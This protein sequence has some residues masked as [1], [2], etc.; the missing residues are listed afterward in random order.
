M[1]KS[2][3]PENAKRVFKGVIYDVYQW[4]Q[5][6]FD[7]SKA[8]FE[9]LDRPNTIEV[10]PVLPNGKIL[11][12]KEWQPDTRPFI[13]F[14]GGR[15]DAGETFEEAARRE[16]HEE[17]GYEAEI[18][19][20]WMTFHPILRINWDIAVFIAKGLKKVAEPHPDPGEK[21]EPL[22]YTFEDLLT[23]PENPE[24]RSGSGPL[25]QKLIRA[26]YDDQYRQKLQDLLRAG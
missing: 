20:L 13:D 9:A 25:M 4:E 11:L 14:P 5:E 16:L 22:E 2:I 1:S 23:L 19:Q 24:Y 21:F 26:R 12:Q 3:I 18:L 17:T 6:L 15:V 8:I 10:I 7:G